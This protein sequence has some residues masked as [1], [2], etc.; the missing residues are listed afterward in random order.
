MVWA[1]IKLFQKDHSENT[2]KQVF[3]WHREECKL[4]FE[5][6]ALRREVWII[7]EVCSD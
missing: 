4:D 2:F 7:F 6:K 3:S 1:G 5:V